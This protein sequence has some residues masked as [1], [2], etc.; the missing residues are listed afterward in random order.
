MAIVQIPVPDYCAEDAREY[1]A[2]LPPEQEQPGRF[3]HDHFYLDWHG[4]GPIIA[5]QHRKERKPPQRK[6]S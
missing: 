2:S 5:T 1:F 4:N 6:R 3:G